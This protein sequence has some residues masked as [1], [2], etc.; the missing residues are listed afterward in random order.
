MQNETLRA[1]LQR[2]SA[3]LER[4]RLH[5]LQVEADL[6]HAE[7]T[8]SQT[9]SDLEASERDRTELQQRLNQAQSYNHQLRDHQ[10]R[11]ERE[12]A[13]QQH[14]MSH[15]EDLYQ[16]S[17][18]AAKAK[19]READA[20]TQRA[21]VALFEAAARQKEASESLARVEAA[22]QR[23]EVMAEEHAL[24]SAD[25]D[26][27]SQIVEDKDAAFRRMWAEV[28]SVPTNGRALAGGSPPKCR[29]DS[30]RS[31][32]CLDEAKVSSAVMS[33]VTETLRVQTEVKRWQ[34]ESASSL[35]K[36]EATEAALTVVREDMSAMGG[37]LREEGHRREQ[38]EGEQDR[39]RREVA[40]FEQKV[41]GLS[42]TLH[43]ARRDLDETT[44][45]LE[46]TRGEA[47][48]NAA[49]RDAWKDNVASLEHRLGE[50]H[51]QL[52]S[53][54]DVKLERAAAAARAEAA[55]RE[56]TQ[57]FEAARVHTQELD[58]ELSRV[59]DQLRRGPK[60]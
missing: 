56:L 43:E 12:A 13:H 31:L 21:E 58:K 17:Q 44:E 15:V 25:L 5:G 42:Q 26:L 23:M 24:V 38:A 46:K 10:E 19:T 27:L 3:S 47:A 45:H 20:A 29:P 50:A 37:R 6:K 41:G 51:R 35:N 8:R 1:D 36:A 7:E 14:E 30:G 39:L 16:Q 32:E 57:R 49:A 2:E 18:A 52:S 9:Q 22:E 48:T 40:A 59:S 4:T 53:E 34:A 33:L 28:A 55:E 60:P 54:R 11:L